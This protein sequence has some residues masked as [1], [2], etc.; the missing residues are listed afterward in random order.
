MNKTRHIYKR[1]YKAELPIQVLLLLD[2]TT[3]TKIHESKPLTTRD[4]SE[5]VKKLAAVCEQLERLS[6]RSCCNVIVSE[7]REIIIYREDSYRLRLY[8]CFP[9]G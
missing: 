3:P 7:D 9:E 4:Q 1:L 8:G 6:R 2:Q 5:L